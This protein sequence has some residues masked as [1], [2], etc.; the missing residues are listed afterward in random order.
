MQKQR[1][2]LA[3]KKRVEREKQLDKFMRQSE[4]SG[5][6]KRPQSSR[7]AR[8]LLSGA[9]PQDIKQVPAGSS[10]GDDERKR[11]EARKALAETLKKEVINSKK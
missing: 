8:S 4:Q 9:D 6:P 10:R 2:L 5:A 7:A 3:E 11:I 1:E